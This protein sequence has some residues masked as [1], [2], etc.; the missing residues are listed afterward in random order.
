MRERG[1]GI[2][3]SAGL[4]NHVGSDGG[5]EDSI[6]NQENPKTQSLGHG[7]NDPTAT[8]LFSMFDNILK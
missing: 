7:E 1:G 2:L 8:G 5:P 4:G 6:T 3:G